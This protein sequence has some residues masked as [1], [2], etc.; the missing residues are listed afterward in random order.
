[1]STHLLL[2]S[3]AASIGKGYPFRKMRRI[4][5]W[6]KSQTLLC[7]LTQYPV[8]KAAFVALCPSLYT[9]LHFA[10]LPK[11]RESFLKKFFIPLDSNVTL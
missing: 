9:T 1:M 10:I 11:F 3:S 2:A 5:C 7:S 4:F 8:R 6:E